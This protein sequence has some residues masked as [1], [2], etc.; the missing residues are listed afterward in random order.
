MR[1]YSARGNRFAILGARKR[2]STI[3]SPDFGKRL[4]IQEWNAPKSMC[5][6]KLVDRSLR[7]QFGVYC[8]SA[9]KVKE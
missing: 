9:C 5:N 4:Q 7:A 6:G 8:P 1:R 2:N 3:G